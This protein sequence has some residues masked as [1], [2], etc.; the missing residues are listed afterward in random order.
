MTLLLNHLD[1]WKDQL[2]VDLSQGTINPPEGGLELGL[3]HLLEKKLGKNRERAK[4]LSDLMN[5]NKILNDL[6]TKNIWPNLTL[7]SCWT[8][9][10]AKTYLSDIMQYFPG[11][12]IQGKGLLATEGI[13]SFPLVGKN[14]YVLSAQSHFYEFIEYKNEETSNNNNIKI[15]LASE[16]EIGKTYSVVI[17]TGGGFYRYQL[18]DLIQVT[19]FI[20]SCPIVDFVGKEGNISDYFGEK[21]NEN[22]VHE[23]LTRIFV[24]YKLNPSFYMMA[25]EKNLKD[26]Y[27]YVLYIEPNIEEQYY[28]KKLCV[29][30][31]KEIEEDLMKNYHYKYS[32][33]LNQL[34]SFTIFLIAPGNGI[35][36][37]LNVCKSHG[38]RVGNIKP[39]ILHK[40]TGWSREFSG[41]FVNEPVMILD[42]PEMLTKRSGR[43]NISRQ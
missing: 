34:H 24:K 22:H 11:V 18:H 28:T 31:K 23:I 6:I 17:T 29:G 13:I 33:H 3:R 9:A 38:Q 7:I 39:V 27:Y 10:Y 32:R 12:A 1:D 15:K 30:L 26:E 20:D 21:L 41:E 25:P 43:E 2:I 5:E 35:S 42:Q 36:T 8:S 16:L 4:E 14:G 19:G 40:R 37:Y